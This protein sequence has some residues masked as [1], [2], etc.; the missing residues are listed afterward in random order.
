MSRVN[1]DSKCCRSHAGNTSPQR[2]SIDSAKIAR[3]VKYNAFGEGKHVV[4]MLDEVFHHYDEQKLNMMIVFCII[5]LQ[6]VKA[7]CCP[8]ATRYAVCMLVV[9]HAGLSLHS[10][11]DVLCSGHCARP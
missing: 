3:L 1:S 8:S 5:K 10:F 2:L 9:C 4:L 11:Q 6:G 7:L